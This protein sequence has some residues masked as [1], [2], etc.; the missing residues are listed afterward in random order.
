[1]PSVKLRLPSSPPPGWPSE[2]RGRLHH[3]S[4]TARLGTA[5]GI[6]FGICFV[7]GVISHYQSHPWM[8][9]PPPATPAGGYRFTQGLHVIT[10]FASIPLL[11]AKLWSVQNKLAQWPP[12]SSVLHALERASVAV[13]IAGALVQLTTG[14]L[15]VLQYY[16]FKWPFASVHYALGWVVIGAL[17]LHIAVKL[18]IIRRG[19]STKLD[20]PMVDEHGLTRRGAV[21]GVGIGAGIVGLTTVGQVVGPLAKVALLAPRRPDRA[22]QQDLPVN[23]TAAA[24]G[25]RKTAVSADYRLT[26][27]G[28]T[29]TRTLTLQQIEAMPAQT[30]DLSIA[31]VE[32]WSRRATWTGPSLLDI[33]AMVGGTADS[34][35]TVSSLEKHGFSRSTITAGQLKEALLA[36]HLHGERLTLD[37]G[38]P[39]R[40][41][42]PDRKGE[43][44]TKWVD[45]VVVSHA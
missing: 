23:R 24:A 8:W 5:V 43:L 11:L 39:L 32:G 7:T 45:T 36:T 41:I 3:E 1:M 26:V 38:Y 20:G 19:L 21:T 14:M 42:A 13:L 35:V 2:D 29:G 17:L 28:G 33:V 10:G 27:R 6:A 30:R 40:L 22:P 15:N 9:L 16:P 44:Q 25:V 12:V 31:C 37:H 4:V 34:I 18:P